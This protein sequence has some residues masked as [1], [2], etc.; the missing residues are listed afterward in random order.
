MNDGA[1]RRRQILDRLL[2]TEGDVETQRLCR[3]CADVVGVT[4][5]GIMLMA[6]D[7]PQ[8]SVC[9]TD[10][11]SALIERLQFDLGE[12]PCI[13]AYNQDRPTSEPDLVSA[14]RWLAFAPPVV[15]AGARAIFGFPLQ[16]GATRLG[17][18]N[19]YRD[20]PGPLTDEQHRDALL[21]ANIAAQALL[22]LQARAPAG[23][24][25]VELAAHADF[26][27]VVHQASGMVAAQLGVTV[28]QALVRLRAHA[29]GNSRSLHDVARDV[30]ARQLRFDA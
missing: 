30:V 26:R 3:V 24:L 12:G 4:G 5:A 8:G 29:F 22:L 28:G 10:K 14:T 16:I 21:M 6:D 27:Y 2:G 13:D 7:V 17:A 15:E 9:T 25:A 18:L 20:A 19:L 11:V 23:T 1:E